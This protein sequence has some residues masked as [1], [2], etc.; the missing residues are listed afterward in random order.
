MKNSILSSF[1]V[2]K[3]TIENFINTSVIFDGI[4]IRS[5]ITLNAS[6]DIVNVC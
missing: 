2:I 3:F 6:H 5:K 1:L 4:L